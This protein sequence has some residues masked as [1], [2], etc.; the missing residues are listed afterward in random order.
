[1]FLNTLSRLLGHLA[2]RRDHLL[3]R[4]ALTIRRG[5]ISL[6]WGQLG[7]RRFRGAASRRKKGSTFFYKKT[8]IIYNYIIKIYSHTKI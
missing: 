8:L 3:H 4:L 1:M 6:K 7:E 5:Y 2:G